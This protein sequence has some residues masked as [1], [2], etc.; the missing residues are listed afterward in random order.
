MVDA[1]RARDAAFGIGVAG[2]DVGAG[3]QVELDELLAARAEQGQQAMRG[4]LGQRLAVVEVVAVLGAGVFLAFHHAGADHA[5]V[6]QPGAQFAQQRGVLAPALHQ[7]GARAFQRGLGVGHALVGIDEAGGEVL[8]HARGVGQQAVGQRL[9]AGL[10]RDLRAG[11]A[12][13]LVGQVEVFQARLAVGGKQFVAQFVGQLAL[14]VDAGQDRGAAVFQLA[15][16][17]QARFQRAQLG[18][19]QAAGDFL[20]VARDE[21]DRGAFVQQGDGGLRLRGLRADLVGDGLGDLARERRGE[22]CHCVVQPGL[23]GRRLWLPA[24]V[25]PSG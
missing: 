8:R 13:G 12:L 20:A 11:T 18:V 17:D 1:G 3:L 15:Q 10:A 24:C 6:L 4:D 7:D 9:Q 19:V 2:L 25:S 23:Q 22:C 5:V 21:R 14:L 16:V